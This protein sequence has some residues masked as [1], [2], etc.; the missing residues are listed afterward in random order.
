MTHLG[1]TPVWTGFR[2]R[3]VL[4]VQTDGRAGIRRPHHPDDREGHRRI[5][6]REQHTAMGLS[7]ER[8]AD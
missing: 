3:G 1:M 4:D 6:Q 2:S 7:F 5:H 8:P